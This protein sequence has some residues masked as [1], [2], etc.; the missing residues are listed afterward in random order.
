[1][2]PI[3]NLRRRS[4]ATIIKVTPRSP[5]RLVTFL[6]FALLV[7]IIVVLAKVFPLPLPNTRLNYI[8]GHSP[9]WVA[10]GA[11]LIWPSH[12]PWGTIEDIVELRRAPWPGSF[13]VPEL[14][15]ATGEEVLT[16]NGTGFDR[17]RSPEI[18]PAFLMLH[19]FSM[20]NEASRTRRALI[21]KYHP[22]NSV[23][24]AYRHL[25][26]IK[27]V[28]GFNEI[29]EDTSSEARKWFEK[30]EMEMEL[31]EREFGDLIRLKGLKGGENMNQGKTLG[32][33]RWVGR[34]GGRESQWVMYA[35]SSRRVIRADF[36]GNVTT[37]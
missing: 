28:I 21:R 32:W 9:S 22:I 4:K 7:G 2:L 13:G 30:E 14:G 10:G 3:G 5:L 16:W 17:T 8:L 34:E 31:E 35:L 18:G 12:K 19:I 15:T 6:A 1:M 36:A 25:V 20:P 29:K 23:P 33:M 11:G 37:M 24:L 26:E 27:F